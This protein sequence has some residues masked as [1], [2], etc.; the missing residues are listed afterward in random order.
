MMAK[1]IYV[2]E[3]SITEDELND[4][5]GRYIGGDRPTDAELL[6]FPYEIYRFIIKSIRDRDAD[7]AAGGRFLLQRFLRGPQEVFF[8][9]NE[10]VDRLN[11]LFNPDDIDEKYLTGLRKLVAF[12]DDLIDIVTA[13][14][15]QELRRIVSGAIHFWQQRFLEEGYAAAVRLV[16]GNR[17]KQR[18]YHDFKFIVG[19]TGIV[20]ELQDKDSNIISVQTKDRFQQGDDGEAFYSSDDNKFYSASANFEDPDDV[21]SFVVIINDTASPSNDGFYEVESVIDSNTVVTK[22]GDEFP[23]NRTNLDWFLA[24]KYDE[25]ITEVRVVDELTGEGALNRTLLKKLL[26]LQRPGSERINLVYVDF[27]DLFQV[28][29]DVNQWDYVNGTFWDSDALI[30]V[31]EGYLQIEEVNSNPSDLLVCGRFND[32]NNQ[33]FR[34]DYVKDGGIKNPTAAGDV[35][36]VSESGAFGGYCLDLTDTAHA[37]LKWTGANIVDSIGNEGTIRF[38][39]LFTEASFASTQE[40]LTITDSQGSQNRQITI[41]KSTST[42]SWSIIDESLGVMTNDFKAW[43]HSV[44]TWYELELNFKGGVGATMHLDGIVFKFSTCSGSRASGG[45]QYM[46]TGSNW[47]GSTNV[48]KFYLD[49]LRIFNERQHDATYIEDVSQPALI[50]PSGLETNRSIASVWS[51]YLLKSKVAIVANGSIFIGFLSSLET[52]YFYLRISYLGF[53]TGTVSL[54]KYNDGVETQLGSTYNFPSL[55]LDVPWTYNIDCYSYVDPDLAILGRFND[56]TPLYN[57]DH[58]WDVGDPTPTINGTVAIESDEDA[59]GGYCLDLTDSSHASLVWSGADLIDDISNEFSVSFRVKLNYTGNPSVSQ[60]FAA[61]STIASSNNRAAKVFHN[62]A[63]NLVCQI[64]DDTGGVIGSTLI[65][66]NWHPSTSVWTSIEIGFKGGASGSVYLFVD[67]DLKDSDTHSVTRTSGMEWMASGKDPV[68]A[69]QVNNFYIEELKVWG[70]TLH[71]SDFS[72]PLN[73][74]EDVYA[75]DIKVDVEGDTIITWSGSSKWIKGNIFYGIND[76]SSMKVYETE[77]MQFPLTIERIGPTVASDNGP[78]TPP[79]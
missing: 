38:R 35:T 60:Y 41:Y 70:R 10:N 64:F 58:V 28:D 29:N 2:V 59:F 69:A 78:L 42:L 55:V 72:P 71:E 23:I 61:I 36:I 17:Y 3:P 8:K 74:D 57:L 12:G 50:L 76:E 66:G 32:Y 33:I 25:Y 49:E 67:G 68:V 51:D 18:D 79:P 34:L 1:S 77:L 73:Q 6:A 39:V 53:G 45:Q 40:L 26:E 54:W 24:F 20:E 47:N 56:P 43:S 19:E 11:T 22:S 48:N 52:E 31:D 27:M 5:F 9:V 63:G 46:A 21:G 4:I 7:I 30:A 44:D 13:A 75:L 14:S 15:T 37:S 65:H 62:T 16:T